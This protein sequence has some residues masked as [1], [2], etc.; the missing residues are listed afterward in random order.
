M[1]FLSNDAFIKYLS[2]EEYHTDLTVADS[3]LKPP[4]TSASGVMEAFD[5]LTVQDFHHGV[6]HG[7]MHYEELEADKFFISWNRGFVA[8][9]HI[10]HT[11]YVLDENYTLK[12]ETKAAVFK[13][14]QTSM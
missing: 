9:S 6:K 1:Q 7:Q 11:Q 4:P 12:S 14:I 13:E 8:T 5:D 2:S 10:C 3:V